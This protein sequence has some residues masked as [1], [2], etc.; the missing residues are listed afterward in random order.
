MSK[1][2]QIVNSNDEP[3]VGVTVTPWA[4]RTKTGHGQWSTKNYG[5]SEP[6]VLTSDE[7]GIVTIRFPRYATAA[8]KIRPQALTCRVEHPN[9]SQSHYN[10]VSVTKSEID[11][12]AT[13]KLLPGALV[14]ARAIA[15]D[16]TLPTKNLFAIRSDHVFDKKLTADEQGYIK[17][18]RFSAGTSLL[19]LV[20][21]SDEG[22]PLFSEVQEL[23][24]SEGEQ[25]QIEMAMKPGVT[26]QGKLDESVPRPVTDG[27]VIANVID[28]EPG[29]GY[30]NLRWQVWTPINA[31]GTFVLSDLPPGNFQVIALCEGFRAASGSP[32][33]FARKI[34]VNNTRGRPQVFSLEDD[35]TEITLK[36]TPTAECEIQV[37]GPDQ[38]PLANATCG[39]SPNVFW[40]RGGSQIY[41][42]PLYSTAELL[43]D[44]ELAKKYF[45]NRS[46]FPYTAKTNA[47]GVAIVRDLPEGTKNFDVRHDDY[48]VPLGSSNR[49]SVAVHLVAGEQ[50]KS[51]ITLQAK[52]SQFVGD[53]IEE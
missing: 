50:N 37:V 30:D 47:Y 7:D 52:G 26:V 11:E 32:P 46:S 42:H 23:Q 16:Q 35:L 2:V 6:P 19:R 39:F 27:R 24:L 34:N 21:L 36:M 15:E 25:L 40:W 17:L 44:P 13:I 51:S 10:D 5:A 43:R 18:A 53:Q 28:F 20:Y 48:E 14:E 1:V 4:M 38:Q 3:I 31:D 8:E 49:R 45:H 12:I 29:E 9:Y 41:G 33:D 22:T